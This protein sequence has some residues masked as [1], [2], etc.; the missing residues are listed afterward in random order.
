MGGTVW[1]NFLFSNLLIVNA[2]Q[3]CIHA[4][5]SVG[6]NILGKK[7]MVGLPQGVQGEGK[8]LETGAFLISE[9][10]ISI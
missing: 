2:F 5:V 3:G 4:S 6:G 10:D 8:P 7:V 1:P 9:I